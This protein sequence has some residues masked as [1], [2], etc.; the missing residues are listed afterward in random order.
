MLEIVR[1]G[2]DPEWLIFSGIH[3]DE[4]EVSRSIGKSIEYYSPR[5]PSFWWVVNAV[6]SAMNNGSRMNK[7]GLDANRLFFSSSC[8]AEVGALL[9]ELRYIKPDLFVDFHEDTG[10]LDSFYLYDSDGLSSDFW[11]I[12]RLMKELSC[13]GVHPFSG[14]D[15]PRDKILCNNII[16]GYHSEFWKNNSDQS[17]DGT[18]MDYMQRHLKITR[19]ITVEIPGRARPEVK[20]VAVGVFLKHLM[21]WY[22]YY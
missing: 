10:A 17:L 16:G 12:K 3:G 11:E 1:K 2:D 19:A 4:W 21:M 5:L 13:F 22:G 6:P 9:W 8:D 14:I 7:N 15:D 18:A 20:D